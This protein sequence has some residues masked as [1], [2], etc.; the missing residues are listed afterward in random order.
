MCVMLFASCDNNIPDVKEVPLVSAT[1]DISGMFPE[2]YPLMEVGQT[3]DISNKMTVV[4]AD[5]TDRAQTFFTTD[6]T[7]ASVN[8][9]GVITANSPGTVTI[10]V[11]VGHGNVHDSFELEVVD[12]IPVPTEELTLSKNTVTIGIYAATDFNAKP[13]VQLRPA[14]A[15][16]GQIFSIVEGGESVA[17]VTENGI[18]SGISAGTATLKVA[19]KNDPTIFATM[20]IVVVKPFGWYNRNANEGVYLPWSMIASQDPVPTIA[21][22]V[23]GLNNAFDGLANT[24]FA[25]TQPGKTTGG[26]TAGANDILWFIVDMKAEAV[27]NKVK[28]VQREPTSVKQVRIHGFDEISGSND[29]KTFTPIITNFSI[30]NADSD[31]AFHEFTLPN[32]EAYRYIRFYMET[33]SLCYSPLNGGSIQIKELYLGCFE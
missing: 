4:P 18:V 9:L 32:T 20:E 2:D 22:C 11:Y 13:F 29:L 7:V 6:P 25:M 26:V 14:N 15:N 3:V 30:P 1:M 23:S 27:V 10:T 33:K 21:D 17:S 12:I 16:D 5:A 19:S 31:A 24:H 8:G 28:I